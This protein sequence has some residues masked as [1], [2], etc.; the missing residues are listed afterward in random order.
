MTARRSNPVPPIK[1]GNNSAPIQRQTAGSIQPARAS[2]P[3]PPVKWGKTASPAIQTAR[4]RTKWTPVASLGLLRVQD[5]PTRKRFR[6]CLR[7]FPSLLWLLC[8]VR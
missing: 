2:I 1:W 3:I 6:V 5:R 7:L 8:R 4:K